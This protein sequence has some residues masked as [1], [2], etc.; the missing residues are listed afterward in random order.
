MCRDPEIWCGWFECQ[1]LEEITLFLFDCLLVFGMRVVVCWLDTLSSWTVCGQGLEIHSLLLPE[2]VLDPIE[3][4]VP[5]G[6]GDKAEVWCCCFRLDLRSIGG[7]RLLN[8]SH[9]VLFWLFNLALLDERQHIL[10]FDRLYLFLLG[11][12][13]SQVLREEIEASL[14]LCHLAYQLS[15]RAL[16]CLIFLRI[17][18]DYI[19][20]SLYACLPHA[21]THRGWSD[22]SL[23]RSSCLNTTSQW[24][25]HHWFN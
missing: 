2:L 15:K 18:D 10:L 12:S 16:S 8:F 25:G 1:A 11:T 24:S 3:L 23:R 20:L 6:L 21:V 14:V 7:T 19:I 9:S 4:R 17:H 5:V 22:C 13:L